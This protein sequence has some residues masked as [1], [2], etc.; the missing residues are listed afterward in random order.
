MTDAALRGKPDAGNPHVRFDEGEVAPAATPRRGSLLYKMHAALAVFA[1]FAILAL[2]VKAV[3]WNVSD[4]YFDDPA[5][6]KDKCI[7]SNNTQIAQWWMSGTTDRT[8]RLRDYTYTGDYWGINLTDGYVGS[9]TLDGTDALFRYGAAAGGNRSQDVAIAFMKGGSINAYM[10]SIRPG[11]K[12]HGAFSFSNIWARVVRTNEDDTQ[13]TFGRGDI[14][15][16]GVDEADANTGGSLSFDNGGVVPGRNIDAVFTNCTVV[17]PL[18][19]IGGRMSTNL[20]VLLSGDDTSMTLCKGLVIGKATARE[21]GGLDE[22]RVA[23]GAAVVV[24]KGNESGVDGYF[25]VGTDGESFRERRVVVEGDGTALDASRAGLMRIASGGLLCVSNAATVVSKLSFT[26][27]GVGAG[28]ARVDVCSGGQLLVSGTGTSPTPSIGPSARGTLVVDGGHMGLV[29]GDASATIYMGQYATGFGTLVVRDGT[30]A[31]GPAGDIRV[32]MKGSGILE[33]HGGSVT[34]TKIQLATDVASGATTNR[35]LQTGGTVKVDADI[36]GFGVVKDTDSN[37]TISVTLDGGVLATTRCSGGS[38]KTADVAAGAVATFSADGGTLRG[39]A[40]GSWDW[41]FMYGFKKAELGDGGL[42]IDAQ[43]FTLPIVQRFTNKQ[44]E[45]GRLVLTGTTGAFKF[46]VNDGDNAYLVCAAATTFFESGV[47]NWQTTAVVTNGAKLNLASCTGIAMKGLLLGDAVSKG[48]LVVGPNTRLSLSSLSVQNAWITLSGAFSS[49]STYPLLTVKGRMSA[50]AAAAVRGIG[51][52]GSVPSGRFARL[53]AEYDGEADATVFSIVF[54]LASDPDPESVVTLDE[55][56]AGGKT[57]TVDDPGTEIGGLS[58][59]SD[60]WQIAGVGSLLFVDWGKS[61]KIRVD[62]GEQVIAVDVAARSLDVAVATGAKL[63]FSGSVDVPAGMFD[64]N[65][66]HVGGVVS[67]AGASMSA[68]SGI[69]H[70][71]GTLESTSSEPFAGMIEGGTFFFNCRGTLR[72]CGD[73]SAEP[74]R[75]PFSFYFQGGSAADGLLWGTAEI[76]DSG[77]PLVVP[78]YRTSMVNG[79]CLVK[80]GAAPLVF[81]T[82]KGKR[83]AVS[84]TNGRRGGNDRNTPPSEAFNFDVASGAT[85]AGYAFGGLNVM[86]GELVYRGADDSEPTA[87]SMAVA[88]PCTTFVGLWST[89]S[90]STAPGIVFDNVYADFGF[91]TTSLLALAEN[92]VDGEYAAK[93]AGARLVV[94]NGATLSVGLLRAGG[95]MV[96]GKTYADVSPEVLVDGATLAVGTKTVL[97]ARSGVSA[98]WSVTNGASFLAG[99]DPVE[100][101]G[102]ASVSVSGGAAIAADAAGSPFALSLGESASGTMLVSAG[103][104]AS[105]TGATATAGA[106]VTLAFDGGALVVPDG[107]TVSFPTGVSLEARAGGLVADVPEGETWTLAS[108]VGG[109]GF[110]T[111]GGA[112][113]LALSGVRRCGFAG[114]GKVSGGTLARARILAAYG[115]GSVAPTFDGTEFSGR[116][117]VELGTGEDRRWSKP[118]PTG[119]VVATFTGS[120][121]SAS[122]FRLVKSGVSAESGRRVAGKFTVDGDTVTMDMCDAPGMIV[123]CR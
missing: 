67:L 82:E 1:G 120:V 56:G 25:Y 18:L 90:V 89:N 101:N 29:N 86:E 64:V 31:L 13:I 3:L 41:P 76:I 71:G 111:L 78:P 84:Q 95:A 103:A 20:R 63:T 5:S 26:V 59:V 45:D 96:A 100:W 38:S 9:W 10:M 74:Y 70:W 80:R 113:T 118:Y 40:S 99:S 112:G 93:A 108:D 32:G 123:I 114:A 42:T 122:S 106:D 6:W 21:A 36:G 117:W 92:A 43:T 97:S 27:D 81:E 73:V 23:N 77:R 79:G 49:S 33:V 53:D 30:L 119:I 60:G 61:A 50:S 7:P 105:V 102:S 110:V 28:T 107:A 109:D 115:E 83:L 87:S 16:C 116:I 57:Y 121:P 104:T 88:N 37:R 54:R 72:V 55:A 51:I 65:T 66:G 85:P 52:S 4:G 24:N 75:L 47:T 68:Y 48:E 35:Y 34:G 22:F 11:S 91:A 8:I 69:R 39:L 2:P 44:G 98:S 14:V 17:A 94:T 58:F 15:F 19:D 46:N 12:T 62:S